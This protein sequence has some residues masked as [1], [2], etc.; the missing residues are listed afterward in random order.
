MAEFKTIKIPNAL[1]EKIAEDSGYQEKVSKD[2][3]KE[4]ENGN[5]FIETSSIDNPQSKIDRGVEILLE[6]VVANAGQSGRREAMNAAAKSFDET[7]KESI[8]IE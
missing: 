4:D 3:S 1:L 7:V 8:T 6:K 2:V 5:P